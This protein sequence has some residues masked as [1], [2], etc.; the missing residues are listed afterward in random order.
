MGILSA[1]LSGAELT[2]VQ[3]YVEEAVRSVLS[4]MGITAKDAQPIVEQYVASRL[5][6]SPVLWL[7]ALTTFAAAGVVLV[8]QSILS[9]RLSVRLTARHNFFLESWAGLLALVAGL[10]L[11][12]GLTGLY[13]YMAESFHD[14]FP[15]AATLALFLISLTLFL[16]AARIVYEKTKVPAL[17]IVISL[18]VVFAWTG[19]SDNHKIRFVEVDPAAA[20]NCSIGIVDPKILAMDVEPPRS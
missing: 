2:A 18:A 16:L 5:N 19:L 9:S 7:W 10:G 4:N 15:A 13:F 1:R 14:A 12:V 6:F 11:H 3:P 8:T 20:A 17:I